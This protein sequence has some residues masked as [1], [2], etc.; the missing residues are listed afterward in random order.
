MISLSETD[1]VNLFVFLL[2]ILVEI[3]GFLRIGREEYLGQ[4]LALCKLLLEQV[5]LVQHD[6]SS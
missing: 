5:L 2:L 3:D 1:L 6:A 4:D